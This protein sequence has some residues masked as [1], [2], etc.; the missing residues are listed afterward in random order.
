[1]HRTIPKTTT[2]A[3]KAELVET[4]D[5]VVS[6]KQ[7]GELLL[8]GAAVGE[9]LAQFL[10][11]AEPMAIA[12]NGVGERPFPKGDVLVPAEQLYPASALIADRCDNLPKVRIRNSLSLVISGFSQCGH[13]VMRLIPAGLPGDPSAGRNLPHGKEFCPFSLR[14]SSG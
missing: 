8:A 6:K 10:L 4:I 5:T 14:V 1:V 7:G 13:S 2:C 11:Q 9:A 12:L 3:Q